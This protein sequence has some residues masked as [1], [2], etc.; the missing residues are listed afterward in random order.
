MEMIHVRLKLW[1]EFSVKAKLVDPDLIRTKMHY[2][3]KSCEEAV[4]MRSQ[5]ASD[6]GR[7]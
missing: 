5:L 3:L 4:V 7:Q 6:S 1:F 2:Q